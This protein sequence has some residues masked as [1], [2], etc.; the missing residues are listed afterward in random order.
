[1]SQGQG[2]GPPDDTGKPDDAGSPSV[3]AKVS[4]L[5]GVGRS[6][7]KRLA[8]AGYPR[9]QEIRNS[10]VDAETLADESGIPRETA[11]SIIE[12]VSL[13][14]AEK[15]ST[16]ADAR[17][18]ASD[19]PGARVKTI[20]QDG[21]KVHKVLQKEREERLPGATVEIRTS[22]DTSSVA[23]PARDSLQCHAVVGS[24]IVNYA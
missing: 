23:P 17:D 1:M 9:V 19:Q 21:N 20:R 4:D 8:N 3:S 11:E 7:G 24:L 14:P 2:Q 6:Y 10:G 13:S 22:T 5:D 15:Q 12:Q 18:R 16:L